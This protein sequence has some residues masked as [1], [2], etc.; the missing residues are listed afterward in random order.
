M[1]KLLTHPYT[2][3]I[4]RIGLGALFIY[5]GL[6]KIIHP[7]EFA[8]SVI[9]YKILPLV[10]VNIFAV[11]LPWL[12]LITGLFLVLGLFTG[13]SALI[14]IILIV[15]FFGAISSA[16]IRGIDITCGCHLPFREV[17]KV[18]GSYLI[19][20]LHFFAAAFQVFFYDQRILSLDK[21]LKK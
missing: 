13:G 16:L 21:L 1:K 4:L 19:Q 5:T 20:E 12:E 7:E 3:L 10:S 15:M 6:S 2:A 9:N 11:I 17:S 14:I 18:N 8:Q